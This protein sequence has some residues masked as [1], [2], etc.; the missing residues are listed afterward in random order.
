M[1][2]FR[3]LNKTSWEGNIVRGLYLSNIVT[4]IN[5]YSVIHIIYRSNIIKIGGY[6]KG[7]WQYLYYV[8]LFPL[9]QLYQSPPLA[10][11]KT[12]SVHRHAWA[13]YVCTWKIYSN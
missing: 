6:P 12:P 11:Y 2:P 3:I 7:I 9:V 5:S 1:I 4:D 13:N 8:I 10:T